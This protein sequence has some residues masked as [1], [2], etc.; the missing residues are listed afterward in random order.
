MH[1]YDEPGDTLDT[2]DDVTQ[3]LE[4]V[5]PRPAGHCLI[6]AI[7]KLPDIHDRLLDLRQSCRLDVEG[8]HDVKIGLASFFARDFRNDLK[9]SQLIEVKVLRQH[10]QYFLM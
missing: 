10:D 8:S 2:F 7:L 5:L 6:K 3:K 4:E 1:V 9:V